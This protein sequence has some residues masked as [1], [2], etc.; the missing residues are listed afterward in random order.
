LLRETRALES[1][2]LFLGL[3]SDE[4][5]S[6][7]VTRMVGGGRRSDVGN[8]VKDSFL[9]FDIAC[10]STDQAMLY[11]S[12]AGDVMV[13]IAIQLTG[14]NFLKLE[15]KYFSTQD[16]MHGTM[17]CCACEEQTWEF[18]QLLNCKQFFE[19]PPVWSKGAEPALN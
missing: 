16:A 18:S 8:D 3:Q 9:L 4:D 6:N 17:S 14:G 19:F 11:C 13:I 5:V 2:H 10:F 12:V 7:D 15:S 1:L